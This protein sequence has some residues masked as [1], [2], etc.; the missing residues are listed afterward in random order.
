MFL[1]NYEVYVSLK[2]SC[3]AINS[4]NQ[5]RSHDSKVYHGGIRSLLLRTKWHPARISS[6]TNLY[7][8]NF[9]N[10]FG[11]GGLMG[12]SIG[13]IGLAV[14]KMATKR[15]RHAGSQAGPIRGKHVQKMTQDQTKERPTVRNKAEASILFELKSIE[16]ADS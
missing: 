12:M 6:M 10:K 15:W 8:V 14:D 9:L 2:N 1:I 13:L 4:F 11:D 5:I 7:F 3:D 16:K